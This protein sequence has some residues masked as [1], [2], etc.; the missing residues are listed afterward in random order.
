MILFKVVG[1]RA[2]VQRKNRIAFK[3][4]SATGGLP[5]SLSLDPRSAMRTGGWVP[6]SGVLRRWRGARSY[7]SMAWVFSPN[8]S[9]GLG[10][11]H[12]D[13]DIVGAQ[14]QNGFIVLQDR[15][16]I[17]RGA[18]QFH[19]RIQQPGSHQPGVDQLDPCDDRFC[20]GG[21]PESSDAGVQGELHNQNYREPPARQPAARPA[22]G[23][24]ERPIERGCPAG[25]SES[26]CLHRQ[27]AA[28]RSPPARPTQT[29]R[30]NQ[31]SERENSPANRQRTRLGERGCVLLIVS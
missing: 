20:L 4:E 7:C 6:R 17:G 29:R 26:A 28:R 11:L 31:T 12:S 13:F 2:L 1:T 25:Q 24:S 15:C 19:L 21:L 8:R 9:R 18:F 14:R 10:I 30:V 3:I 5:R 22:P 23:E 16:A 27:R